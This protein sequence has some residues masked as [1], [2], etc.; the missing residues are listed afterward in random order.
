MPLVAR[1]PSSCQPGRRA[2]ASIYSRN[3]RTRPQSRDI[4]FRLWGVSHSERRGETMKSRMMHEKAREAMLSSAWRKRF[5]QAL[6]AILLLSAIAAAQQKPEVENQT[7]DL[8][9]ATQI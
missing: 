3:S 1:Q 4:H 5:M 9:K 6:L 7:G 2:W 8:Q